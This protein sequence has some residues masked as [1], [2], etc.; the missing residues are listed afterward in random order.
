MKGRRRMKSTVLIVDDNQDYVDA[1]S[2]VLRRHG[3]IVHGIND[4]VD[5]DDVLAT[6]SVQAILLD[7]HM[8][9]MNGF[10]VLRQLKDRLGPARWHRNQTAKIVV[11]TGRG[12]P[13]TA[14]F[15]RKLG[16]DAYLVKPV[17]PLQ[18]LSTLRSLLDA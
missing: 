13:D 17:D 1:L 4:G 2:E 7:L 6:T 14:D 8:P 15:I 12:E 5:I 16:A 10:E 3:Y 18:I 11:V 9:G